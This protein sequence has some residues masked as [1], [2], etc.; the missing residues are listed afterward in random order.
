MASKSPIRRAFR[1]FA[2][3]HTSFPGEAAEFRG[4]LVFVCLDFGSNQRPL[5]TAVRA[6]PWP[7]SACVA[8]ALSGASISRR[9]GN[10]QLARIWLT[11]AR[12]ASRPLGEP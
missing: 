4:R 6:V 7:Q 8:S 9:A 11:I 5:P 10:K 1:A 12:N 2:L 3:R